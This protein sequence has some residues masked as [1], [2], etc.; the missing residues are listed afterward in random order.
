MIATRRFGRA[1]PM[2]T[3]QPR[4][5]VLILALLCGFLPSGRQSADAQEAAVVTI[6]HFSDASELDPIEGGRV[7]GF[8]RLATLIKDLKRH[9]QPLLLTFG[10]DYLS[11]S[12]IGTARVNGE[13]LAGRQT[14]DVLNRMGLDWATFGNHEF[15]LSEGAFR[16]RLAETRFRIVSSNVTDA[17]GQPFPGTVQSA[18]VPIRAGNRELRLGLIGLTVDSNKAPWVRYGSPIEAAREQLKILEGRT[19]AVIALTHLDL[20]VDLELAVKYP[21]IDVVLGG[22]EHENWYVRRG[23]NFTP[24]IIGDANVRSVAVVTMAFGNAGTRPTISSRLQL[25]DDRIAPDPVVESE[26]RRWTASAFEGF[27]KA[28]FSPERVIA[29]TTEPLDGKEI[30]VR[31]HPGRLTDLILAG[32]VREAGPADVALLNGG[33]I[34]IDDSL[35]AGPITEYDAIRVLPFGGIVLKAS[36]EGS[37]LAS[38]LDIG[39]KNQGTGGFLQTWGVSRQDSQWFV[40]GRPLDPMRRYTVVLPDFLLTGREV[41]LSFLTRTN[42]GVD[43]VQE[44]RDLRKAVID[45]LRVAYPIAPQ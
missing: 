40:Q 4:I 31:N 10:G 1:N 6:V 45:E 9:N 13:S 12:A 14:V 30:T 17:A 28:G 32:F 39:M 41:N 29:T 19:D 33:A 34:R 5:L 22:H 35:P 25:V 24:V 7:G 44:F 36:F 2:A 42:P 3:N 16:A 37:L 8:S 18:V 11:P 38:V 27:K 43:T 23:P 20:S 21:G 15:D 26:I